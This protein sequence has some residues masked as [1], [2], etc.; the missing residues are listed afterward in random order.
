[1]WACRAAMGTPAAARDKRLTA[2]GALASGCNE[3][4]LWGA[5][6][7]F[8]GELLKLGFE[9]A[10]STVSKCM[11]RRRGPPSQSRRAFLRNHADAIAAIWRIFLL[12]NVRDGL[13]NSCHT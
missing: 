1:M 4:P 7:V 3:N 11:I 2:A 8:M 13:V 10:E 12:A 6:R 5:L 9:L